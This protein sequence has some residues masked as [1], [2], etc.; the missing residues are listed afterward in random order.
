MVNVEKPTPNEVGTT[1]IIKSNRFVSLVKKGDN[2]FA[3]RDETTGNEDGRFLTINEAEDTFD[4]LNSEDQN[5][6]SCYISNWIMYGQ[7]V[8]K[9]GKKAFACS[10]SEFARFLNF[11]K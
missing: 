3:L 5:A 9:L 11:S 8:F 6:N 4:D 7:M 1:G 2:T 10:K